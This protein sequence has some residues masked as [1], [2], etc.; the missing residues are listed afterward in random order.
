MAPVTLRANNQAAPPAD[1]PPQ[2]G[3]PRGGAPL[4]S[5]LPD[6]A[7]TVHQQGAGSRSNN[8]QGFRATTGAILDPDRIGWPPLRAKWPRRSRSDERPES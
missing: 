1:P 7:V 5:N 3:L 8:C 2:R 4:F 6:A